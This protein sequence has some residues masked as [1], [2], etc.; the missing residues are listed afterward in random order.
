MEDRVNAYRILG[1]KV[2]ETISFWK[3]R[4]RLHNN[5]KI[6]LKDVGYISVGLAQN[7]DQRWWFREH[8]NETG[9]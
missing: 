1:G 8:E 7:R 5:I 9:V 3:G 2:E 4:C 6:N